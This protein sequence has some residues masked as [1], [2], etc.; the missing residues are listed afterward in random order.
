MRADFAQSSRFSS[1]SV[2]FCSKFKFTENSIGQKDFIEAFMQTSAPNRLESAISSFRLRRSWIVIV[3]SFEHCRFHLS[4]I[5][6]RAIVGQSLERSLQASLRTA[7]YWV[8]SSKFSGPC[9]AT[10]NF[11]KNTRQ[12]NLPFVSLEPVNKRKTF[13]ERENRSIAKFIQTIGKTKGSN[14]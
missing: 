5:C 2:A 7:L 4:G 1:F 6:I 10:L 9:V 14:L 12:T 11:I 13:R 8:S 3:R